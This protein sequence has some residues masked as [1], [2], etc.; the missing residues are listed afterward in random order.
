MAFDLNLQ[1]SKWVKKAI[2]VV[3]RDI[4]SRKIL[5]ELGDQVVDRIRKRTRLGFGVAKNGDKR[6]KLKDMRQHSLEYAKLR[7][8][9]ELSSDTSA[10]KHNLTLTGHMLDKLKVLDVSS[11][12]KEIEIGFTNRFAMLKA[13]VNTDLG[14]RFM[15]LSDNEIK[16]VNNFYR[17]EVRKLAKKFK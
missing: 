7:K 8:K 14:W 12:K 11:R 9:G 16:A 10:L 2:K 4:V 5:N 1:L 15:H 6:Q 13:R 3:D 17:R